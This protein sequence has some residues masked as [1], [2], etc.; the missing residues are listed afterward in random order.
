M[1]PPGQ[2][3]A[4]RQSDPPYQRGEPVALFA[5]CY[6][7]QFYPEIAR[8]SVR[9]LE[10]YDVP[11]V[12]P[13]EQ[14][15]CGQPAFNSGYWEEAR[16]VIHHFC[17]V[18]ADHRWIVCPS[19]SCTAMCRV[20]FGHVDPSERVVGVGRRVFELT[21]FLVD[22]LGVTDTGA[23]FPHKVALH[24]GCHGRR[25]LGVAEA[26]LT[27]LQSVRGLTYCELPNVEECCGFGGTFSVKM[28]GTSLAMGRTKVENI[29][30]SGAEV[31]VSNDISCLMH[32]GGILQRNPQ[33]KHIRTMHIAEVLAAS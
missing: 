7:D 24:V 14:T 5:P 9:L 19:G 26:P 10:R 6:I 25:E 8:A 3:R 27:L 30:R 32:I 2:F 18:F 1:T 23:S 31:V 4:P 17:K 15:C 28:P 16:R 20:F 22:I 11:V 12:F 33:T 29:V 21:E 13:A